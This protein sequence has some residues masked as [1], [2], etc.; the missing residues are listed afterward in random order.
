LTFI[1]ADP[2]PVVV[3]PPVA[4][5][6]H[7]A[8]TVP[9]PFT[10][11]PYNSLRVPGDVVVENDVIV[12]LSTVAANIKTAALAEFVVIEVTPVIWVF[13]ALEL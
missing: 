3:L 7:P 11:L 4:F 6:A 5:I 13:A 1:A 8:P 10:M 2:A 12:W 9:E